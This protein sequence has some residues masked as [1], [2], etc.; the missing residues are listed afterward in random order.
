MFNL[1]SNYEP[2][3]VL[4]N[5]KPSIRKKDKEG[6]KFSHSSCFI[7]YSH[8]HVWEFYL[9]CIFV[10]TCNCLT[11]N[12]IHSDRCVVVSYCGF[13]FL[14]ITNVDHHLFLCLFALYI[15]S[16]V[17]YLF[18]CFVHFL[19]QLVLLLSF[20]SCLYI[21]LYIMDTSPLSDVCFFN[22]IKNYKI[23]L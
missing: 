9:L 18:K 11:F 10:S 4:K 6:V 1:K 2:K 20:E 12:F 23:I 16:L 3:V 8:Q 17:K 21:I 14:L 13:N 15:S 7:F 22:K 19:N 5:I